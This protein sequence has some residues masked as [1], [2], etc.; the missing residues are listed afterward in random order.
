MEQKLLQY[1]VGDLDPSEAL[2]IEK[3]IAEDQD[4]LIE[5]E[6]LR[7]IMGKLNDLPNV[8]PPDSILENVKNVAENRK[9]NSTKAPIIP[10][11]LFMK[12]TK[13]AVAAAVIIFAYVGI[14]H[15]FF[16]P[17]YNEAI[18]TSIKASKI[19][20]PWKD[21]KQVISIQAS[22]SEIISNDSVQMQNS[23]LRPV[24]EPI[25]NQVV[26]DGVKLATQRGTVN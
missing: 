25:Q 21:S 6:S 26:R 22:S 9:S 1:I 12:M 3:Q 19:V 23:K 17:H 20:E 8:S 16:T 13:Y 24:D 7:L 4:L 5:A 14:E 15:T 11:S 10:I 18:P 2:L